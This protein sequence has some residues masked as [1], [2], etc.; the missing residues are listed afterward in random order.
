VADPPEARV[1]LAGLIDAVRLLDDD[2]A[3][4]V[5]VPLNP[6]RLA[7]FIVDVALDPGGNVTPL[8]LAEIPK[9]ATLMVTVTL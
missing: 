8:G 1:T 3:V 9:S 2:V 7:R 6:P 4:S 5:T